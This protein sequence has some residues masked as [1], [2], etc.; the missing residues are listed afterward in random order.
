MWP[1]NFTT[2]IFQKKKFTLDGTDTNK[3]SNP[4]SP[5]LS[6]ASMKTAPV[7]LL[8]SPTSAQY[9]TAPTSVVSE[10][11]ETASAGDRTSSLSFDTATLTAGA[12]KSIILVLFNFFSMLLF[13]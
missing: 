1:K 12:G 3:D 6:S 4:Q 13:Y 11:Y 5:I 8:S 2:Q 10:T 7:S 9:D